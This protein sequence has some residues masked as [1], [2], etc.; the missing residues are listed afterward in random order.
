VSLAPQ[1]RENPP[2]T[3]KRH[4]YGWQLLSV[5]GGAVALGVAS[6][7]AY[8]GD[9]NSEALGGALLLSA[10]VG[11]AAGGP[12]VHLIHHQNWQALGSLGLRA[13][14]PIVGGAMGLGSATCP[15]PTGD[16]GNCGAGGLILGT[17]AGVLLA[18]VLDDS[19]LAWEPQRQD[20]DQHAQLSLAPV[21][22]S[23][24]RRELRL[25]GT[26]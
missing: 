5:D 17:A 4:W 13:G 18:M 11:Y 12:V 2:T 24:G 10:A 16:Y 15:P 6:G 14:L 9:G 1:R 25:L 22:A 3:F 8:G 20:A 21:I 7:A 19:L 23:D 26:F